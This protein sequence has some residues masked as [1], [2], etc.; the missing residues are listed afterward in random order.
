MSPEEA[1][2]GRARVLAE[3]VT[4]LRT[5]WHHNACVKGAGVD[6]GQFVKACYVNTGLIAPVDAGAYARDWMLHRSEETLVGFI[7]RYARRVATP[8]PADVAVWRIGRTFSHAAIVIAWPQIIHA[9]LPERAVVYGDA[10][11]GPLSLRPVRFYSHFE[12]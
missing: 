12:A 7:E 6:C 9:H 4:W 8:K 3:A 2:A 10:S 1:A 11:R 5:I